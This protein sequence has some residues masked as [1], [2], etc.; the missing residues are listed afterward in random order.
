M[1]NKR[2]FIVFDT[3]TTGLDPLSGHEIVQLSAIAINAW[4]LEIHHAGTF[5]ALIKPQNPEVAE[6]KAIDVI[7]DVWTK[8]NEE[9]LHP[10]V[11]FEEFVKWVESVND[12]N[13]WY[14]RPMMVAHNLDFDIKFI[15]YWFNKYKILST[16]DKGEIDTP[17]SKIGIDTMTIFFSM[18]ESDA[19]ITDIKLDTILE[20]LGLARKSAD[21][22]ALEDVEL[23]SQAFVRSLKFLRECRKRMRVKS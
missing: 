15:N 2:N 9:G 21:H 11:V 14:S 23:L 8:A 22:N 16:N 17:W 10:K 3:E 12:N 18:F 20:K 13:N 6:A 1:A 4:N 7:G 19:S 5:N